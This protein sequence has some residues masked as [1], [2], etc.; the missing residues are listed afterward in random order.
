MA[1]ERQEA[2][3]SLRLRD[4]LQAL[5]ERG[6]D[7][8]ADKYRNSFYGLYCPPL[9]ENQLLDLPLDDLYEVTNLLKTMRQ[10]LTKET[11]VSDLE[12]RGNSVTYGEYYL[13][14]RG[15]I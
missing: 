4:F 1:Q 15:L 10:E 11:R 13:K 9:T 8:E 14:K 2:G 12:S 3:R 7:G 5:R 6:R